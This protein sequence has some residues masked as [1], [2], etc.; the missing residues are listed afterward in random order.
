MTQQGDG[1]KG[2][3]YSKETK[4]NTMEKG[5]RRQLFSIYALLIMLM[6]GI[7]VGR[8]WDSRVLAEG[9]TYDDLK[10]FAEV[11]SIVQKN[12]VEPVKAKDL[13]YGAVRG[14]LNTLDPHSAFMPPEV[15]K[16][17]QVDTRG[18][19]GGLGIQIGVK[20]G[21]LTVI[22]PIEDTPA[23]RAGIKPGDM[24]LKVDGDSTADMTLLDA[25]QKM[26]GAKGTKV[27]LTIGRE[28]E[29][30]PLVFEITRDIIKIESIRSRVIDKTIGYIRITQFQEQTGKDL[31]K[32]MK[33]LKEQKV[34][35]YVV[36][37]R[38]NPGGLLSSAVEVSEQ[39]LEQGRL[40]VYIQGRDQKKDEYMAEGK[41]PMTDALMIVLVNAGSASASEIVAGAL[42][43]WG[44]AVVLGTTTFG[45]GSV[46]TILP[47]SDGS[48]LRLTTARY[49]TP[50]GRSIQ[51]TGI[52]P[53]IVVSIP[54]GKEAKAHSIPTIRERDLERHLANP[55]LSP[56]GRDKEAPGE[57][58]PPTIGDTKSDENDPQLKTA[59]E[60][61]KSW[62]I[63]KK[64]VPDE[65]G[66]TAAAL[67]QA[68]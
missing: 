16:E 23:D 52:V 53:D 10:A 39:F 57:G 51:N 1:A 64:I 22:A 34:Q 25:V 63:F 62:S 55:S 20:E 5:K 32:A 40:V 49:Y 4:E 42:Q 2:A 19:F 17:V 30:D 59:V 18:E 15:Y 8:G 21:R 28:G 60:L 68:P 12:Y 9:E 6:V 26:R 58:E 43:D 31:I 29:A 41:S 13:V 50:K 44:R 36:D 35:S 66:K 33:S 14:M 67:K 56:T 46:Q 27:K 3:P 54:A 37:L 24:I 11:L 7:V 65:K 47:L 48:G 61:L 45:K 38:N